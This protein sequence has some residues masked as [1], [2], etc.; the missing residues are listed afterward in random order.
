VLILLKHIHA[1]SE[2]EDGRGLRW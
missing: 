1:G 2:S